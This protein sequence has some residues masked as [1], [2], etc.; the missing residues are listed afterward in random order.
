MKKL[1]NYWRFHLG[2]PLVFCL[3][4]LFTF[5]SCDDSVQLS[6]DEATQGAILSKDLTKSPIENVQI[7]LNTLSDS[8]SKIRI[9][10]EKGVSCGCTFGKG[11][12]LCKLPN[13]GDMGKGCSEKASTC[14]QNK[15]IKIKVAPEDA[16]KF[17]AVGF[18]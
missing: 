6:Y 2:T 16:A 4:L 9:Y 17:A 13:G 1:N 5:S 3:L 14:T 12:C 11:N 7:H 8:Y 18:K 15:V 10:N